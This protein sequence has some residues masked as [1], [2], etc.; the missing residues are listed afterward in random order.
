MKVANLECAGQ[1]RVAPPGG[2]TASPA[3]GS[4]SLSP[5]G[6][7]PRG[8]AVTPLPSLQPLS[9]LCLSGLACSGCFLST[10]HALRDFCR[11]IHPVS[12][13]SVSSTPWPESTLQPFS[14]LHAVPLWGSRWG[15]PH[16][17]VSPSFSGLS[18]RWCHLRAI[19]TRAAVNV[20]VG[21]FILGAEPQGGS[22]WAVILHFT[23]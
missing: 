10:S 23:F 16:P 5:Q 19:V 18:C 15:G 1:G 12:C 21:A 20:R 3:S 8:D 11:F 13:F 17:F 14:W 22:R 4:E 9:A 6:D 7:P 2:C